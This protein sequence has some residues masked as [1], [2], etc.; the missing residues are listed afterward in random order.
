MAAGGEAVTYAGGRQDVI[1]LA[2]SMYQ[3]SQAVTI[4]G[5]GSG[6]VTGNGVLTVDP[7]NNYKAPST[8]TAPLV[9]T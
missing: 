6:Q 8:S 2:W 9:P 1:D 3:Q 5:S 7:Q 4:G